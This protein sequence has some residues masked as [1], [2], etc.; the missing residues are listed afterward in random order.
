MKISRSNFIQKSYNK[1]SVVKLKSLKLISQ[2]KFH[3]SST[4][5]SVSD[6]TNNLD[7]EMQSLFLLPAK[8]HKTTSEVILLAQSEIKHETVPKTKKTVVTSFWS[9]FNFI[10]PDISP[11]TERDYCDMSFVASR[12]S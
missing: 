2:S 10:S 4:R 11:Y 8:Q 3:M 12:L 7:I 5:K 9:F 1:C 6:S